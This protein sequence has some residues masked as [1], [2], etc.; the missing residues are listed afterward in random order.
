MQDQ[1]SYI[2]NREL[3]VDGESVVVV[4]RPPI[5]EAFENSLNLYA[6]IKSWSY[7]QLLPMNEMS[8]DGTTY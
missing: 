1:I 2:F 6:G 7:S 4:K 5:D 8:Y 3:G